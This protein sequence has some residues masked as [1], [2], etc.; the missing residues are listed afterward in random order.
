MFLLFS[1]FM[2]IAQAKIL[3]GPG[4]LLSQHDP[5]TLK[6]Q[7]VLATQLAQFLDGSKKDEKTG[8]HFQCVQFQ[9]KWSCQAS[10][11]EADFEI[12]AKVNY[13][14]VIKRLSSSVKISQLRD[15][16]FFLSFMGPSAKYLE[17]LNKKSYFACVK[18]SQSACCSTKISKKGELIPWIEKEKNPCFQASR[19]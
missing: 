17:H 19:I 6:F 1:I 15:Q 7:G 16:H 14:P 11:N 3:A 18:M 9:K 13:L 12:T 4:I 5:H 10:L 2:Q 8:K